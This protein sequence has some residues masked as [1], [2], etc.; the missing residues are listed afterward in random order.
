MQFPQPGEVWQFPYDPQGDEGGGRLQS[1]RSTVLIQVLSS[2]FRVRTLDE[3]FESSAGQALSLDPDLEHEIEAVKEN[4]ILVTIPW[5][6]DFSIVR[7]EPMGRMDSLC[8][9]K[10]PIEAAARPESDAA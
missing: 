6:Q 5:P 8:S 1:A 2:Q 7:K 3:I 10:D 4:A 9:I